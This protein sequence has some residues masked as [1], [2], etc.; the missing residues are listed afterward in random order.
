MNKFMVKSVITFCGATAA[1]CVGFTG[2]KRMLNIPVKKKI[3][4]ITDQELDAD[5][6]SFGSDQDDENE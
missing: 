5:E 1:A 2:M 6:V 3:Q 4:D